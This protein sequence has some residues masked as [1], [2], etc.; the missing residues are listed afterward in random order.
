VIWPDCGNGG[1]ISVR[2]FYNSLKIHAIVRNLEDKRFKVLLAST[3]IG[4]AKE[5]C[6]E[7][8]DLQRLTP[9]RAGTFSVVPAATWGENGEG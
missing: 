8:S 1:E 6:L 9:P 4:S 7:Y 2:K 3:P 5:A